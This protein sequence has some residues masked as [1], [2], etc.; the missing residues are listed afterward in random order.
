MAR[1]FVTALLI[2]V[3]ER[4]MSVDDMQWLLFRGSK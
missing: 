3:D 4:A 2:L 1:G